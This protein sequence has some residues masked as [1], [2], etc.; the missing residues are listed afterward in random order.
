MIIFEHITFLRTPR[1][2]KEIYS[3]EAQSIMNDTSEKPACNSK[4]D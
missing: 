1:E 2:E 4:N 3:N